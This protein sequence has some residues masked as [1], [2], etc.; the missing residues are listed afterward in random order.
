MCTVYIYYVYIN[1]QAYSIYFENIYV[2]IYIHII[3][4]TKMLYINTIF[5][6]CMHVYTYT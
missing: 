2:S 1:A 3:Y 5:L 6:K 4:I